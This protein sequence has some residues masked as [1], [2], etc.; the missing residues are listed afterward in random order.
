MDVDAVLTAMRV[1]KSIPSGTH[2]DWKIARGRLP[3]DQYYRYGWSS[4][5]YLAKWIKVKPDVYNMHRVDENDRI[6]DVVMEDSYPELSKHLPIMNV[7]YGHVLKTGLGLG[8]VV[9]GLLAKPIVQKISVIEIDPWII[10]VVGA[11]F[12]GNP[13]VDIYE[14]DAMTFKYRDLE[15]LDFAW[16]DIWTPQNKDLHMLHTELLMKTRKLV[17][18]QGAWGMPKNVKRILQRHHIDLKMVG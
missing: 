9:R 5:T 4:Y 10:D 7:A 11:E 13:R 17:K 8:C 18:K 14:A 3:F 15:R 16:H 2:G 6:L 12:R 1:P